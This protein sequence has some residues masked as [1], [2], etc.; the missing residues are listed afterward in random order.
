MKE[1]YIDPHLISELS[2]DEFLSDI[3]K[4]TLKERYYYQNEDS[5]QQ[6]FARVASY[7]AKN[8]A[9]A[10]RL[11]NYMSNLWFMPATPILSNGGTGR[12]LPVSCYTNE[13]E[14]TFDSISETFTENGFLAKEG[15]GIGTNWSNVRAIGENISERGT[16]SGI[17]PFIGVQEAYTTA[18]SQGSMR[19]GSTAAYLHIS[20]PEVQEFIDIRKNT[21]DSN[22]RFSNIHHGIIISDEFMKAVDSDINWEFTRP[23]DKRTSDV[24][25]VSARSLWEKILQTRMETG[26]PYLIFIDTINKDIP[27]YYKLLS[28]KV[29]TSNLCAE[30][31]LNTKNTVGTCFLSSLNL[32]R[33]SEWKDNKDFLPDVFEFIDAV[34]DDFIEK[35]G[36]YSSLQETAFSRAR[37]SAIAERSVGIGVMGFHTLLQSR[38]IAVDSQEARDLNLEI[39]TKLRSEANKISENLA[40]EKG[41]CGDYTTCK[42]KAQENASKCFLYS[43]QSHLSRMLE[44][45]ELFKSL[46]DKGYDKDHLGSIHDFLDHRLSFSRDQVD[47]TLDYMFSSLP[48]GY[49]QRHKSPLATLKESGIVRYEISAE[50]PSDTKNLVLKDGGVYYLF[51]DYEAPPKIVKERFSHKLA[52]APTASISLICGAVSPGIDPVVANEWVQKGKMGAESLKNEEL[53]KILRIKGQNTEETWSNIRANGGSVSKLDCLTA[54]EKNVFKTAFEIDQKALVLLAADRAKLICQSQSLNLFFPPRASKQ[55]LLDAHRLA[56]KKGVKSLYYVRS[57][58]LGQGENIDLFNN[59][60]SSCSEGVCEVCQ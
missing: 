7:Y 25:P 8:R 52:I 58:S 50:R 20:H 29:S 28:K 37:E 40:N 12:G 60:N 22:R 44:N 33:Y 32:A 48:K 38:S 9:Q 47:I 24:K 3:S 45:K 54:H 49:V 34:V 17:I 36:S 57:Q 18:V 27:L 11:Y 13:V 15:G 42:K 19:R 16:T 1:E 14:D 26:E 59:N 46:V 43:L 51:S 35:T 41:A 4:K 55:E 30:I 21:G 10:K 23:S 31:T 2:R 39:F 6:I 5:P 53:V 56:H